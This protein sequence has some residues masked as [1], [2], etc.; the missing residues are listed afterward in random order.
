[1]QYATPAKGKGKRRAT[2]TDLPG[3]IVEA[4][5]ADTGALQA[6]GWSLPPGATQ[7]NYIR[8]A[9]SFDIAP[10]PRRTRSAALPTVAR[11][12]V[13][14]QVL[15]R[16]TEAVSVAERVHQSLVKISNGAPVF[17]GKTADGRP[18]TGHRHAHIWCE[19]VGERSEIT[20]VTVF[21]RDSFDK[22]ARDA[23]KRLRSVWGHGGHDLQLILLGLGDAET[24]PDAKALGES[25]VWDSLTPFVPTRHPRNHRDG[26]PKLDADGWHI[27]SPAHDLRR[28]IIEAGLPV[29][30]KI[31][32]HRAIQVGRRALRC[33]QFRRHR[34]RGTGA[35]FGELGYS[36]RLI[37]REPVA[38]PLAFGYG[39]HFGLGLFV[40]QI[41]N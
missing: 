7:A 37:F 22:T 18:M 10:L 2:A 19:A 34:T 21:A 17:T 28:L 15:P 26:R 14:S 27:G 9:H 11:F 25:V 8:S 36:F 29:P 30:A 1:V 35:H 23:L 39:A 33:L 12:A 31:E 38:G 40:P 16:I 6:A 4:L 3:D 24:F 32:D 5:L 20:R 13:A 41:G